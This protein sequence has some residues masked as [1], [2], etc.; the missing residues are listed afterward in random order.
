[1]ITNNDKNSNF[2]IVSYNN[3]VAEEA[4]NKTRHKH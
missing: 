3:L 2:P 4:E 1:V